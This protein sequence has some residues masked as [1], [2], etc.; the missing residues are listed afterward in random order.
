MKIFNKIFISLLISLSFIGC[1][2]NEDLGESAIDTSKPELTE[3][4][5][6]IRDNFTTPYNIEVK[7]EWDDSEVDNGKILSPPKLDKVKPFLE[8]VLQIWINPYKEIAGDLFLKK[9]VPRQLVL[10]GSANLNA[11][12]TAVLGEA[13][14]GRK[15]TIYNINGFAPKTKDDIRKQFHTMHHEFAHILH[16]TIMYPVEYKTIS[17]GYTGTW[18]NISQLEAQKR[19][20]ITPYAM[21][22][23]SEDFVEMIATILTNN[24]EEYIDIL[25]KTPDDDNDSSTMPKGITTIKKKEQYVANYFTQVWEMNLYELQAIIA[26]EMN[27]LLKK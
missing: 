26:Y 21:S 11:E 24:V 19:G 22:N 23:P 15:I 3:L 9:Y 2:K 8:A 18:F 14:S 17:T 12:G 16:Q 7:Y 27:E 1:E 5:Q 4:D 6:W 25:V 20:F 13:E 10:V